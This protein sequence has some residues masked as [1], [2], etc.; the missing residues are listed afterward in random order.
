MTTDSMKTL[1]FRITLAVT[2]LSLDVFVAARPGA[3]GTLLWQQTFNGTANVFGEAQ[4]VAV[5]NQGTVVAAGSTVNT[6]TFRDFTVAKFDRDGTLLW[7]QS[8]SGTAANSDDQALSVAV[9]KQ[10]NVVAAGLTQ[11]TGTFLDFTVAKFE[12]DGTLL[13]QQTLNGTDTFGNDEALSVAADNQGNVVAAGFTQNT[14]TGRDFT[15]AKFDR[16]GALLWQQN[17]DG[18]AANS[19]S[20]AAISVAVD[21]QGNVVAAGRIKNTGISFDFAVMKFDR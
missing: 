8:L 5:D 14:G 2:L 10:G 11:N 16:D 9:D 19:D 6:G 7:Q 21:N 12:G 1:S 3:R 13:W 20:D 15:V 4:S 17:L 18:T